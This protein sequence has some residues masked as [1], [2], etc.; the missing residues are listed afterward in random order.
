MAVPSS[1]S[2]RVFVKWKEQTV[3]AGEDIECEITFKN[4]A[5]VPASNRASPHSNSSPFHPPGHRKVP[6][7]QAKGSPLNP[8]SAQAG[9]G[10]RSTLS[11]TVPPNSSRSPVVSGSWP[12][13][14]PVRTSRDAGK[15]KRSVSI[16]SIGA[17]E[18]VADESASQ[19]G[20]VERVRP[21]RGHGRAASLQIVPRGLGLQSA[22][23]SP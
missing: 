15:H 13:R 6:S 9:R 3:F 16:I 18:S 10:H 21:A 7:S 20:R 22:G 8:H 11:L 4:I 1:S 14:Q 17:N 5:S 23:T 2:I 12:S 19:N